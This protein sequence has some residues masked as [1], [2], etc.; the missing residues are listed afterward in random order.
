[1]TNIN[2]EF[3]TLRIHILVQRKIHFIILKT[4]SKIILIKSRFSSPSQKKKKTLVQQLILHRGNVPT[5]ARAETCVERSCLLK[6]DILR[7]KNRRGRG[8]ERAENE[9]SGSE[10][11]FRGMEY[12]KPDFIEGRALKSRAQHLSKN[13]SARF[14]YRGGTGCDVKD[15]K[16]IRARTRNDSFPCGWNGLGQCATRILHVRFRTFF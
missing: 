14:L 16:G 1:M 9:G 7:K 2:Q 12:R 8:E 15:H 11:V 6:N 5:T 3:E 4:L 13:S 10:D